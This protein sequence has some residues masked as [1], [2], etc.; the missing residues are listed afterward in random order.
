MSPAVPK[1]APARQPAVAEHREPAF[2]PSDLP[3]GLASDLASELARGPYEPD[4]GREWLGHPHGF[5]LVAIVELWERFGFVLLLNLLALYLNERWGVKE[6]DT[7]RWL[8]DLTALMYLAPLLGGTLTAHWGRRASWVALGAL[9]L[10]LGFFGLALA[11]RQ[12][13]FLSFAVMVIGTGLYK[14][15]IAALVGS[16][17][18]PGDPRRDSAFSY[19]YFA[20]NIGAALGP[21]VGD[22]LRTRMG[23]GAAFFAG[24]VALTMAFVIMISVRGR[25]RTYASLAT[26]HETVTGSPRRRVAAILLVSL[27]AT[28]FWIALMQSGFSLSFW[29]RDC[30]DRVLQLGSWRWEISPG[31]YSSLGGWFVILLTVPLNSLMDRLRR[32]GHGL[33]SAHKMVL[34]LILSASAFGLLA[35]ASVLRNGGQNNGQMSMLWLIG[36]YFLLTVGELLL[37]PIGL[38]VVSKL[39]PPRWVS[40]LLG[41][42]FLSNAGGF[43]AL[44]FVGKLWGLWPHARYFMLLAG[45]LLVAGVVLAAQLRWLRSVLPGEPRDA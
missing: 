4:P 17:Y 34:G 44:R 19:F 7:S 25:L 41:L 12:T 3:G 39:A 31:M 23:W 43:W 16:L 28:P 15:N 1:G 5:W 29:A 18:A 30:T 14:P 6:A 11:A 45:F 38:S 13:M 33:S 42:W 2:L 20:V 9:L 10:A 35:L 26:H 37:S 22:A 27:C 36:C 40:A 32:S 8:G 21:L 24:G